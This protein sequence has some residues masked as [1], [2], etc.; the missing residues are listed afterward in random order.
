MKTLFTDKEFEEAKS[1]DRLPLECE[2]CGKTFLGEKKQIKHEIKVN[3]GRLKYCSVECSNAA[4]IKKRKVKCENC[5]KE[6]TV[7]RAVYEKSKTKHFFCNH[8]CAAEYNNKHRIRRKKTS[9]PKK[10]TYKP[11]KPRSSNKP[12]KIRVLKSNIC[13]ICGR[14][15][16]RFKTYGATKVFCSK[17][18]QSEYRNNRKQYLSKETIEKYVNAGKKS[19]KIQSENRR[20]KNEMYFCKLCEEHFKDVKHNEPIFNGWD[21]DVIIEDIKT[22]VLWNGKWHYQKITKKHSLKQ[23][24][25]RDR[26]K[27]KEIESCGYKPYVIKDE[28]KYNP[29]FV[30]EEFEKF[31]QQELRL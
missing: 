2:F 19:A 15:Y 1:Q 22:A 17:E 25:N 29:K 13:K 6:L 28:G 9:T 14:E 16:N 24:Q 3:L 21:A 27:I 8:S 31:L 23:V 20:S 30:R 26:I 5:G 4:H 10:R 11:T 12:I 7:T 18:C